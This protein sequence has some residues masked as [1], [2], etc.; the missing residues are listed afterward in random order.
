MCEL[1]TITACVVLLKIVK[2]TALRFSSHSR[3][4]KGH[5]VSRQ[6]VSHISSYFR[7]SMLSGA[8]QRRALSYDHSE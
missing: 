8:T 1:Y 4:N 6:S 3:V 7:D 5:L 2:T